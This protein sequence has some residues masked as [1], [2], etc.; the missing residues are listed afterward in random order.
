ML[1]GFVEITND[2]DSTSTCN[3]SIRQFTISQDATAMNVILLSSYYNQDQTSNAS[4]M[5]QITVKTGVGMS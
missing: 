3:N 4:T 5:T 1:N 2:Q